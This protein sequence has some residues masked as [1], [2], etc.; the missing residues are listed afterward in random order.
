[1]S[2]SNIELQVELGAALKK[3][4]L[5]LDDPTLRRIAEYGCRVYAFPSDG[6]CTFSPGNPYD[7]ALH[8]ARIGG[9]W[10]PLRTGDEVDATV[11]ET[12]AYLL[13]QVSLWAE[14][15]AADIVSSD[16]GEG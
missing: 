6:V 15:L 10:V 12:R 1:L 9:F 8:G 16:G 7:T 14:R 11:A 3:A 5:E 4:V 2:K 13:S